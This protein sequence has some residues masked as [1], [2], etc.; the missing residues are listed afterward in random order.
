MWILIFYD[1]SPV[2]DLK[3]G[4]FLCSTQLILTFGIKLRFENYAHFYFNSWK[5]TDL[6][7]AH[8]LLNFEQNPLWNQDGTA[9]NDK[10]QHQHQTSRL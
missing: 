4:K 2:W 9:T 6:I 8:T 5:Y 7:R 1:T 10:Q 3:Y